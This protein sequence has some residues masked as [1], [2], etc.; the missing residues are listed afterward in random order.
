MREIA[1]KSNI[2]HWKKRLIWYTRVARLV[3]GGGGVKDWR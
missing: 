2:S 1:E 3:G